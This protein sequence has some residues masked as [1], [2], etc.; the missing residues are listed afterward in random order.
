MARGDCTILFIR[1]VSDPDNPVAT[2]EVDGAEV[3][4]I[5]G[6]NNSTPEKDVETFFNK[7]KKTVLTDNKKMIEKAG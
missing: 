2:V 4:Q 3:I 7:Y 5:R 1:R 6:H